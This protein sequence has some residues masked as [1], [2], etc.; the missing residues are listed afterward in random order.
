MLVLLSLSAYGYALHVTDEALASEDVCSGGAGASCA[1]NELQAAAKIG[2]HIDK[3]KRAADCTP[4]SDQCTYSIYDMQKEHPLPIIAGTKDN[5][6]GMPSDLDLTGVW[7]IQWD[8][9]KAASVPAGMNVISKSII[10]GGAWFY[11][12]VLQFE[13]ILS[14]A[15]TNS[16]STSYPTILHMP[17]S[18]R[19]HWAYGPGFLARFYQVI[20]HWVHGRIEWTMHNSSFGV[21]SGESLDYV[22]TSGYQLIKT[23]DPDVWLRPTCSSPSACTTYLMTRIQTADGSR[24]RWF[25]KYQQEAPASNSIYTTDDYCKRR[26][27]GIYSL[28]IWL[29]PSSWLSTPVNFLCDYNPVFR[30]FWEG[31]LR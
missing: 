5:M 10:R 18:T 2:L 19:F 9:S 22:S 3:K 13:Q 28:M 25:D 4:D 20:M 1:L 16:S 8:L 7:W 6:H 30:W 12:S 24:T 17:V 23:D 31:L 15:E 21:T 14:W 26:A 11:K 29:L 27:L